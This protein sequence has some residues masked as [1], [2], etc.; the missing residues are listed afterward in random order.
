MQINQRVLL[1]YQ[2]F[3]ELNLLSLTFYPV[4]PKTCKA[5]IQNK[6]IKQWDRVELEGPCRLSKQEWSFLLLGRASPRRHN[7][8]FI[9]EI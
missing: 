8:S 2:P 9:Q 3:L 4:G 5:Q 1:A 7:C 6:V